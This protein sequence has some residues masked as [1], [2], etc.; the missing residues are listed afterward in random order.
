MAYLLQDP[1]RPLSLSPAFSLIS[2]ALISFT[3]IS[4]A[5]ISCTMHNVASSM[6]KLKRTPVCA[7]YT[8][9]YLLQDPKRPISFLSPAFSP[10]LNTVLK[11]IANI[12]LLAK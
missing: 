11:K 1:K 8:M 4:G 5:L 3:L 9:A 6:A 7:L 10:Y 2:G 12:K